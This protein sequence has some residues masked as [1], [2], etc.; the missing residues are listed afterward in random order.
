MLKVNKKITH[1]KYFFFFYTCVIG[2]MFK[3]SDKMC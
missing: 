1:C 2:K 3:Y